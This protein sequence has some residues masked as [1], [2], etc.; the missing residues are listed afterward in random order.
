MYHSKDRIIHEFETFHSK[1]S[2]VEL[3]RSTKW[4]FVAAQIL[5]PENGITNLDI[6]EACECADEM[7]KHHD[8]RF[9]VENE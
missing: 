9:G 2:N 5:K 3:D 8:K 4:L 7:M 1:F 6:K